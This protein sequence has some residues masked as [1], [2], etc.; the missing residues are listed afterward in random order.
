MHLGGPQLSA[1]VLKL[2]DDIDD[3]IAGRIPAPDH[4]DPAHGLLGHQGRDDGRQL[5]GLEELQGRM[6]ER[7]GQPQLVGSAQIAR[8]QAQRR[9]LK[10]RAPVGDGA[11]AHE[12]GDQPQKV[13][14]APADLTVQVLA[15]CRGL[16]HDAAGLGE[17]LCPVARELGHFLVLADDVELRLDG[18]DAGLLLFER[19]Q[20]LFAR[21]DHLQR[22]DIRD[23]VEDEGARGGGALGTHDVLGQRRP[24][25][26]RQGRCPLGDLLRGRHERVG[27]VSMHVSIAVDAHA[28]TD[29][30]PLVVGSDVGRVDDVQVVVAAQAQVPV[31]LRVLVDAT[32][33]QSGQEVVPVSLSD[34]AG[35]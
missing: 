20:A 4:S 28:D 22:L 2:F 30:R 32:D 5:R 7:L 27:L 10:V 23:E 24:G 15:Q 33:Q 3:L 6:R 9:E 19:H 29:V 18:L 8:Y 14:P 34:A 21:Q 12:D 35:R 25:L 1:R 31:A 13:A 17:R 16:I 26:L 11:L